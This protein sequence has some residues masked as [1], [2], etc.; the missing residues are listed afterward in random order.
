MNY[1][2]IDLGTTNSAICSYDGSEIKVYKSPEQHSVTPSAIYIDKRGRYYG[3]RAYE[4]AGSSPD[5]V[6]LF[7]KRFMG[8]DTPIAIPAAELVLSPE[9]CSAEILRYLYAYLPEEVRTSEATGTVITIPAAFDQMQRDATLT[10]AELA[11]IGKVA[12]MQEPV[13]AVMSIMRTGRRDGVF[14]VYDLGGGTFD[15]AV[16]ESVGGHVSLLDHGGIP[17]C[18][19]RDFDR[20]LV[21]RVVVPWMQE[22]FNLPDSFVSGQNYRRVS[23][24][25]AWASEKAK[26]LLSFSPA[27]SISLSEDEIR[28]NDQAGRPLYLDIPIER[29]SYEALIRERIDATVS[30][31]QEALR[32][33]GLTGQD[34]DRVVFIGGPTQFKPLRDYVCSQIGVPADVKVDPMTA[35]AEGAALFAESIDWDTSNRSRKSSRGA[36]SVSGA[37]GLSFEFASRTPE[38][39]TTIVVLCDESHLNG[40]HF[41][42]DNLDS[43][44][45]SGRIKL[46]AGASCEVLIPKMGPNNFRVSLFT[47]NGAPVALAADRVSITRTAVSIGAIPASHSIGV[48]VKQTLYGS[49]TQLCYLIEKGESLPKKGRE[50]FKAAERLSAGSPGA[51]IIKL[52]EGEIQNPVTDNRAVGCLK[53]RGSDF[54]TGVI[55][56]GDDLAVDYEVSDSG[57]ISI[58]VSVPSVGCALPSHDFYSRQEAQVDFTQCQLAIQA[59]AES[60]LEKIQQIELRVQDRDLQRAR[61][62]LDQAHAACEDPAADPEATKDASQK[63][64]MARSMLSGIRTNHLTVIRQAELDRAVEVFNQLAREHAKPSEENAFEAMMRTAERLIG[65]SSGGFDNVLDEMRDTTWN[66]LWRQDSFVSSIF[67]RFCEQPYLFPD[68]HAY[69]VLLGTGREALERQDYEELRD[70][71]GRLYGMKATSSWS[72]ELRSANI[73]R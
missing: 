64:Q 18:G 33:T 48:E 70:I 68:Q 58:M 50:V 44:W 66:I 3:V 51:L 46:S 15:V 25:A 20:L 40:E 8:T 1:I 43:G 27:A 24:L 4:K 49:A 23:K 36:V 31:T 52:Y 37:L 67:N 39:K 41:Q 13:A 47:S 16:A 69:A 14:V 35:V 2:G 19:G 34:I 54:E 17:L 56:A 57:R 59:E 45:S 6:A 22:H 29:T 28:L 73:V 63:V 61:Q 38:P 60:T 62:L 5:N 30:A 53:I 21:E 9:E 71:V 42:I 10:A 72:D 26:I 65:D 55:R 7:F 32:R 11:G 12:L